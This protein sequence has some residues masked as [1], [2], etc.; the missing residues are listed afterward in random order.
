ME[1]QGDVDEGADGL[2]AIVVLGVVEEVALA[3]LVGGVPFENVKV[4]FCG[5]LGW[6]SSSC[7]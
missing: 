5:R 2:D 4:R 3:A 6:W 1:R 7:C